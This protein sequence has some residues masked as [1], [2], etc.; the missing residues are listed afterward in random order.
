MT[1]T[2]IAS[3]T[4]NTTLAVGVD[5]SGPYVDVSINT[6]VRL[7]TY[8][9]QNL[10]VRI[11]YADDNT[12]DASVAELYP[13]YTNH[14]STIN[15]TKK[16]RWAKTLVTNPAG[17]TAADKVV[18]KTWHS[19]RDPNPVLT[20]NTDDITC[21]A[22]FDMDSFEV[23]LVNTSVGL[24]ADTS[25]VL[26]GTTAADAQVPVLVDSG[27]RIMREIIPTLTETDTSF[28]PGETMEYNT[29]TGYNVTMYGTV[30]GDITWEVRVAASE[31]GL[32]F[33]IDEFTADGSNP[34]GTFIKNYQTAMQYIQLYCISG[35]AY[36][37][38][39]MA[40]KQ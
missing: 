13:I 11:I 34:Y 39:I 7:W 15:S 33:T 17:G 8:A 1:S 10:D 35:S 6:A 23:S 37:S 18:V 28:I 16:K 32:G 40:A 9:D 14:T 22:T 29:M 21:Q 2:A 31:G 26:V 25:V 24:T 20:Y 4:F 3:N 5:I 12:G 36:T 19:T 30:S 38:I 27:G